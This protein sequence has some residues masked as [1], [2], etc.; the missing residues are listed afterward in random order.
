MEN[1]NFAPVFLRVTTESEIEAP[2]SKHA[3]LEQIEL[4]GPAD[5]GEAEVLGDGEGAGVMGSD[6]SEIEKFQIGVMP[7]SGAKPVGLFLK[8]VL[9]CVIEGIF[10]EG[11][12]KSF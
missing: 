2:D 5:A 9:S 12:W 10:W 3:L 4:L 8:G 1:V 7:R 11:I 6:D